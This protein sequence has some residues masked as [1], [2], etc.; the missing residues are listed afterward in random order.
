MILESC[1]R[2]P[3][4]ASLLFAC[5]TA[6][7]TWAGA[8]LDGSTGSTGSFSGDFSIPDS[9]GTTSGSNLFHSFSDF[10]INTGESATFFGPS[11]ITNVITRVTGSDPSTFNGTLTSL[12]DPAS[13]PTGA[14]FIFINPNGL[15]FKEG[16]NLNIGGT[17]SATTSK[18]VNLGQ[19]GG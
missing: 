8:T 4:C 13:G 12:I 6:T 18:Y 1:N 10:S 2:L 9:V 19:N 14:N 16:A 7:L 5:C 15:I 3:A 11:S 17:F